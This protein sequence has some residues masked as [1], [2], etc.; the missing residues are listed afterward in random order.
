[1]PNG[2]E[3]NSDEII[4]TPKFKGLI[5]YVDLSQQFQ[6]NTPLEFFRKRLSNE[7][8]ND[9]YDNATIIEQLKQELMQMIACSTGGKKKSRK[10][11]KKSRKM[12]KSRKSNKKSR[13]MKK[14]AY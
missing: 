2:F 1:M 8:S 4:I 14:G 12:K 11:N 10:S 5:V 7:I 6:K 13:K 3:F 9:K